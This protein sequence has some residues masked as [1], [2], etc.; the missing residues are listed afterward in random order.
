ML[1]GL[2]FF[3]PAELVK[4]IR[5]E[6]VEVVHVHSGCWFKGALAARICGIHNIIYTLHGA[7]DA[8]TWLYMQLERIASSFTSSIVVV[9]DDLAEQMRSA[10][11]IPMNKVSVIINGINTEKFS[12]IPINKK[13]GPTLIGTIARLAPVKDFGTLLRAMRIVLDEGADVTLDLI[14]DG[15][16]RERLEQLT[17]ELGI[18]DRVRFP[19]FQRDTPQRLAEMDIFVLSSLSEGTSISILEAMSSGKPIVATAVG[20]NTALVKEGKNGFLVPSSDPPALARALLRLID[21]EDLRI[22]MGKENRLKAQSEYG[23]HAMT[24][25]YEKLYVQ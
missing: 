7:S 25:Q 18:S 14:G 4:V 16:E 3:Y 6:C 8:Q 9:S 24:L 11:H 12:G 17:V 2:S 10:G 1:P 20:G 15:S 13:S 5:Q 23:L 19:G 21:D 22:L